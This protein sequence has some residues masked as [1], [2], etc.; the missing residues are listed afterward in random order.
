LV[1]VKDLWRKLPDEARQQTVWTLS[2]FVARQLVPLPPRK[3]V[4]DEDC[5][6]DRGLNSGD[7]AA[8]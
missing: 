7:G 1:L 4:A 3:E 2:Q 5:L 6:T 8:S